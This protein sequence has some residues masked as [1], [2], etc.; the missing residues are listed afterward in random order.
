MKNTIAIFC[1]VFLF[2]ASC[3]SRISTE[4][5][6]IESVKTNDNRRIIEAQNIPDSILKSFVINYRVDTSMIFEVP[7]NGVVFIRLTDYECDSIENADPYGYES[8]SE[9]LNN[10]AAYALEV[11]DSTGINSFWTDKKYLLFHL[12]NG[13]LLVDTR[14]NDGLIY[15]CILFKR[16][17]IPMVKYT[18]ELNTQLLNEYFGK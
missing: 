1:F 16:T 9:N 14:L 11:V 13:D 7:D 10:G 8:F 15:Y 12:E 6:N 4:D 17:Q 18:D 5:N 2:I 3:K